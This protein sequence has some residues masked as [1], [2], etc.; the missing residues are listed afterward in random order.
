M[1]QLHIIWFQIV[2]N[3]ICDF[4]NEQLGISKILIIL[5]NNDIPIEG[6]LF[7]IVDKDYT[8]ARS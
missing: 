8:N 5:L 7:I 6:L 1:I 4:L 3:L 2:V